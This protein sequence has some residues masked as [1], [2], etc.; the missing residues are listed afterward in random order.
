MNQ[1]VQE[2]LSLAINGTASHRLLYVPFAAGTSLCDVGSVAR[3]T[4]VAFTHC[5]HRSGDL[6]QL[7]SG[8]GERLYVFD[9]AAA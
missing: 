6:P 1:D 3:T 8:P 5:Y 4:L 7:I 9:P 2:I